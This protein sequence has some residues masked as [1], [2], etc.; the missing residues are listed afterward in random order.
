MRELRYLNK[1]LKK[2]R[3]KLLIGLFIT[4]ISRIFSLFTPRLIGNSLTAVE[5]FIVNNKETF[6]QLKELMLFNIIAIIGATY[7][8]HF[9]L[10]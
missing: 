3:I 1:Y 9:S 5:K 6:E 10:F 4:I 7:Y 2:Y 8:Q